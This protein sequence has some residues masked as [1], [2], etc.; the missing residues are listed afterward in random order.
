MG[1]TSKTRNI[2]TEQKIITKYCLKRRRRN[3]EGIVQESVSKGQSNPFTSRT[4]NPFCIHL[5]IPK[6]MKRSD[7]YQVL[8]S[9]ISIT[10]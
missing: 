4:C 2:K 3:K 8:R 9:Y 1:S 7:R 6:P 5:T 10:G